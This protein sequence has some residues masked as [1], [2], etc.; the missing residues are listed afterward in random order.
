LAAY[1]QPIC[2]PCRLVLIGE[3]A[4]LV[5]YIGMAATDLGLES[6][7]GIA[8]TGLPNHNSW[9]VLQFVAGTTKSGT[10]CR[11]RSPQ[12]YRGNLGPPTARNMP[13]G[14]EER[15]RERRIPRRW[16]LCR[17]SRCHA[18]G[19]TAKPCEHMAAQCSVCERCPK[20]E[21]ARSRVSSA[22]LERRQAATSLFQTRSRVFDPRSVVE[23][24]DA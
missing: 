4:I 16:P 21:P 10:E 14:H 13:D 2:R 5:A 18:V 23:F 22:C 19:L 15:V 17:R 11:P 1:I 12:S 24:T 9:N 8:L 6:L 3:D 7:V 20:P